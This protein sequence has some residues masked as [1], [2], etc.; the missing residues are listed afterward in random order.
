M[1]K[2]VRECKAALK[3]VKEIACANRDRMSKIAE[4]GDVAVLMEEISMLQE[5][6]KEV[7]KK[8]EE[9]KE[10]LATDKFGLKEADLISQYYGNAIRRNKGDL[11]AM[12][13]A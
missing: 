6:A 1:K 10:P 9:A 4:D 13:D 5:E 7:G 8:I 12:T 11:K 3:E 2:R